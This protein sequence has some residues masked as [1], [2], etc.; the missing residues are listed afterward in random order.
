MSP[1]ATSS[2]FFRVAGPLSGV[3]VLGLLARHL[4]VFLFP[5]LFS[6]FFLSSS[7][8]L[9][10]SSFLSWRQSS[11]SLDGTIRLVW[12]GVGVA[13]GVCVAVCV[14]PPLSPKHGLTHKSHP[15]DGLWCPATV[16]AWLVSWAGVALPR[17]REPSKAM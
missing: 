1:R 3:G 9:S 7:F 5:S 11:S 6:F 4:V 16:G 12:Y 2:L 10:F 15:L 8:L 14:L 17:N 13:S